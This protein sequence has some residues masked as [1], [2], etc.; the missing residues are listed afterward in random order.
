ME[1]LFLSTFRN[2][3]DSKNRISM[4]SLFREVLSKTINRN[5]VILYPS[6]V[7]DCI[8]GCSVDYLIKI[9]DIIS[10]LDL[11][12]SEKD[13]LSAVIFGSSVKLNI[14]I[15]GRVVLP[16]VLCKQFAISD[17]AVFIGK[18]DIFEMWSQEKFDSYIA[19]ARR[20]AMLN[21]SILSA[22]RYQESHTVSCEQ[23]IFSSDEVL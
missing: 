3:I 17:K 18:G 6:L 9:N 7:N 14:D 8:E 20:I 12:S 23:S 5:E 16:D 10:K 2:R 1:N 13:A 11:F 21:K 22:H 4:P 19:E 15:D